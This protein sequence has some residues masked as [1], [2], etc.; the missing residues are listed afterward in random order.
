LILR[1]FAGK[2]E[3]IGHPNSERIGDRGMSTVGADLIVPRWR[4][5][6]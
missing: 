3:M 4:R 5:L 2:T 6:I 1:P